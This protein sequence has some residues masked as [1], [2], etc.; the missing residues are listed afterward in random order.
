MIEAVATGSPDPVE[1][2]V[3]QA[4]EQSAPSSRCTKADIV[5]SLLQTEQGAS[6]ARLMEATGWQA[7][8]VRGFLSAEVLKKRGLNLV[9][10]VGSNG[11]R[12]YRIDAR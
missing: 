3:S 10:A 9:S 11:E 12:R 6:I 1:A 7:H 8:S 5:L 4:P 2:S